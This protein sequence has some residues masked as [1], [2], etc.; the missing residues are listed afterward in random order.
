[1]SSKKVH[2]TGHAYFANRSLDGEIFMPATFYTAP[3]ILSRHRDHNDV[4]TWPYP[5]TPNEALAKLDEKYPTGAGRFNFRDFNSYFRG[6]SH[7]PVSVFKGPTDQ[8]GT[9]TNIK[10]V[11]PSRMMIRSVFPPT[12]QDL[13]AGKKY[14]VSPAPVK[15]TETVNI[16]G[17]I[18][19][20][21]SWYYN[22]W[23]YDV[24]NSKRDRNYHVYYGLRFV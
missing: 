10:W 1:M 11:V 20:A 6:K 9:S 2:K 4:I 16:N 7:F 19:T 14:G 3:D 15:K 21:D 5:D 23:P 18:F 13:N 22:P 12:L 24:D 8:T 17:R